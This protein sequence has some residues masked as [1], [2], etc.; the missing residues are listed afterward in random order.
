[1]DGVYMKC[2]NC[3]FV[4]EEGIFCPECGTKYEVE[5]KDSLEIPSANEVE[6]NES[7]E[8]NVT[9]EPIVS[10]VTTD[11]INQPV[12]QPKGQCTLGIVS[13]VLGI[14]SVLTIGPLLIPEIVGIIL[15]AKGKK[16]TEY[17]TGLAK[18]GFVINSILLVLWILIYILLLTL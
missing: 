9:T 18:A 15:G 6:L 10:E 12:V 4:F 14:A 2:S 11:I 5:E 8:N 13:F 17:K 1:M 7:V 3:G 16:D